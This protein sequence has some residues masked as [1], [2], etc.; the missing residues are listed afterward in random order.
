MKRSKN[1]FLGISLELIDIETYNC[2][3]KSNQTS[4]AFL[5]IQTTRWF[6]LKITFVP[7]PNQNKVDPL[8]N[9]RTY[10]GQVFGRGSGGGRTPRALG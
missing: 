1:R 2:P 10:E 9:G 3:H 8:R 6:C 5:I 7:K 4:Q